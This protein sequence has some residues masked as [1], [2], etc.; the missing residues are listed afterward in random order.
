MRAREHIH[1]ILFEAYLQGIPDGMFHDYL[2]HLQDDWMDQ[3]GDLQDT[4]HEDIMKKAKAKY[5]LLVNSSKWGGG[6]ITRPR[7][8]HSTRNTSQGAKRP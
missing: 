8:D 4:M 3:K 7:K 2:Q 6:Q 5:D 1:T